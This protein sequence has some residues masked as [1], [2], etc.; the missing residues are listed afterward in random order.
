MTVAGLEAVSWAGPVDLPLGG[1][2]D[3]Q[4]ACGLMHVHGRQYG[5]PTRLGLDY[6]SITATE[7]AGIGAVAVELARAR[8]N[9]LRLATTSV[10]QAALLAVSP[11]LA[12][13]TAEPSP[14]PPAASGPPF[15]SADRVLFELGAPDAEVWQ[16]FWAVLDAQPRAVELGWQPFVQRYDTATCPLPVDLTALT[17]RTP[18][19]VLENA[20]RTTGM[21]LVR[22]SSRVLDE[23][24]AYLTA[25]LGGDAPPLPVGGPLP[26]AGLVVL[27]SCRRVQGPMAGHLLGLLGATVV[28]IEPPGGDPLRGVPPVVDGCSARFL[29][30]NRGKRVAEVD[31][32]T[33]GGRHEVLELASAADVFLHD[34]APG[35]AARWALRAKDV[36]RA[37]PGV[38]YAHASGWGDAWGPEPPLSNDFVVQAHAGV[39]PSMMTIVDLFGGLVAAH[40]IVDALL[41]RA[42]TG[43][44]RSVES[45]L[46]SAASR[47]NAGARGWCAAPLGVPVCTDLASLADDRRFA[48]ALVRDGCVFPA[49]PWEFVR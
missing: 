39:P 38:V 26:L 5:R 29:A 31:L 25:P 30:L 32:G 27:E 21:T 35:K 34:W 22:V 4:A 47:L 15:V 9:A 28:R 11:Y 19:H 10:A 37:R 7:L 45:S 36:A 8:G 44:G 12:A 20:A 23:M 41:R 2:L 18:I 3:V 14:E 1:E 17:G 40:G 13:A 6:A 24:P 16:R 49:S 42:H 48:R 33:V 43:R 46:L